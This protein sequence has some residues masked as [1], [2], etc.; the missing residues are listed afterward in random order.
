MEN[1]NNIKQSNRNQ[2]GSQI[3]PVNRFGNSS[4]NNQDVAD[5]KSKIDGTRSKNLQQNT[6]PISLGSNAHT[7][8]DNGTNLDASSSINKK[9]SKSLEG[10][11]KESENEVS[12]QKKSDVTN[13]SSSNKKSALGGLGSAAANAALGAAA[14][15]NEAV[16]KAVNTA[17]IVNM[18]T[19]VVKNIIA[20][21]STPVGW[22]VGFILMLVTIFILLIVI[23]SMVVNSLGMKFGLTGQET[24]DI[25]NEKYEEALSKDE[26]DNIVGEVDAEMCKEGVFTGFKHFFGIWNLENS[27]E[28]AHYVKKIIEDKQRATGIKTISPGYFLSAL[29]YSFDTQNHNEDGE[30]FIKTSDYLN[31]DSS[32]DDIEV[33]NDLDAITTL[34]AVKIYN[35]DTLDTLLDKYVF[36]NYYTYWIWTYFPPVKPGDKGYW[37]CVSHQKDDYEI[38]E[39]KFKLYL[40]YGEDVNNAYV[41]ETNQYNAYN[42]TS[43]QCLNKLNFSRPDIS[44]YDIQADSTTN[45]DDNAKISI[46]SGSNYGA[47]GSKSFKSGTYGYDSGFIFKTYPR[48][49]SK[50]IISGQV[51]YDYM[52][53]K[54]IEKI[55]ET[56]GSRQD[57]INYILGYP[58]TVQTM[59]TNKGEYYSSGAM[60]SFNLNGE[61][62]SNIKVRL[63][64]AYKNDAVPGFEPWEPI[65]GQELIDFDKYI[66]GVVYGE[67]GG[68]PAEAMKAQ[69]IAATSYALGNANRLSGV[70][71]V[72]ENGVNIL[73]ISNSNYRQAYCDPDKGCYICSAEG[74]KTASVFTEGTVPDGAS[75]KFWKGP[76]ASNSSIRTAVN[77]VIGMVLVDGSGKILPSGYK[78]TDQN[79]WNDMARQG[80]DY[81]EI[82]R[83]HYGEQYMV[84]EPNC[85]YGAT[86]DWADWKQYSEPWQGMYIASSTMRDVGCF[87]TCHSIVLAKS[88]PRLTI[89]NFNPGT[90]LQ[91]LKEN[92]CLSGNLLKSN[93]ALQAA[94]GS[95]V[96]ITNSSVSISN[97]SYS[98]KVAVIASYLS[99]GY[100]IILRVK[101]PRSAQL[102]SESEEHYV[103]VTGVR[104]NDIL[105]ADPASK[106][107][108]VLN[109]YHN[110]GIISFSYI[111][112][113]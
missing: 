18:V 75:C 42:S 26:I 78:N 56:T 49:N 51:T 38:D 36:H 84:S 66:L 100:D 16:A 87:I 98:D 94:V 103:V 79:S 90:F 11:K 33:I 82:L 102:Y 35:K 7:P 99:Q 46:S 21:F 15:N 4:S 71:L 108:V 28:F 58:N 17:R 86:G 10:T 41:Y 96:K 62:V 89:D 29:Y 110:E 85:S 25:F 22:I 13:S 59:V 39:H 34:M 97:K 43:S 14:N 61:D 2:S 91:L 19:K 45:D 74:S 64:H 54:D 12:S 20:F 105:M 80:L 101:S 106:E 95:G 47:F 55:I 24:L 32:S 113:E 93:C 30:L 81:I 60:C 72:Q 5:I 67:E 77:E 50:Y 76:L 88:A 9:G 3:N 48:Y 53:D 52:V 70:R 104:G 57:Y 44:K 73:E 69:A 68:A 83:K 8:L 37:D 31:N 40:R 27:C 23:I 92:S 6:S 1:D 65:E 111:K 109:R 112:F 63:L 107:T